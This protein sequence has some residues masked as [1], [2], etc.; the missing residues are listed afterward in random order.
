MRTP[1]RPACL[2]EGW[3]VP[4]WAYEIGRAAGFW[5]Q[6][7]NMAKIGH[8]WKRDVALRVFLSR[9]QAVLVADVMEDGRPVLAVGRHLLD[10][11][12]AWRRAAW[13]SPVAGRL[14]SEVLEELGGCAGCSLWE[15]NHA[16]EV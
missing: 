1:R 16:W 13:A 7:T 6:G 14:P 4:W 2:A 12:D 8:A 15:A 11:P 10:D 5:S 3:G 9:A